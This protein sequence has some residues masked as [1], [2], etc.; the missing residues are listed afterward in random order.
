MCT[1]IANCNAI[2][3]QI[4]SYPNV[5]TNECGLGRHHMSEKCFKYSHTEGV[6]IENGHRVGWGEMPWL[7]RVI[8]RFSNGEGRACTVIIINEW[9]VITA[10]HCLK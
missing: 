4:K 9:W 1:A 7:V 5:T 6:G 3:A 10:G 2:H 8:T